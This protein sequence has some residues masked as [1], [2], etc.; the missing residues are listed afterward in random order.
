LALLGFNSN[1][2]MACTHYYQAITSGWTE[3]P[4]SAGT[5]TTGVW[6]VPAIYIV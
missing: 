4:A 2:N 3:M 6:I 5:L 1:S